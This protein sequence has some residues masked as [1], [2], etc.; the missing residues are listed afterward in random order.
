M[1]DH[2]GAAAPLAPVGKKGEPTGLSKKGL[3]AGTVGLIAA[4]DRFDPSH[5]V[6]LKTYYAR[7][8]AE[9]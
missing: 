8:Y 3:S 9:R 5:N 2:M 1:T 4:I 6:K 7:N